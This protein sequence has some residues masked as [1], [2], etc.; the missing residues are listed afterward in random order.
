MKPLAAGE[1]PTLPRAAAAGN[2]CVH[3]RV[4]RCHI[5]IPVD[6]V[7]EA[8]PMPPEGATPLPRRSGALLGVVQASGVPVPVV[9]LERWLP[10]DAAAAPPG[11]PQLVLVLHDAGGQVGLQVDAV[12]GVKPAPP[13]TFRQVHHVADDHDE[14]FE[15]VT[16][17]ADGRPTLCRLEVGRL[18]RLSRVWCA[19]AE[20]EHLAPTG[21]RAA[22]AT[23]AEPN[24]AVPVRHAVFQ[25]GDERWAVPVSA[26]QRVVPVPAVELALANGR[27]N[28][29]IAEW[30]ARKLP[31]VDISAARAAS[32][33]ASAPWMA[34]L[35]QGP[36]ALGLTVAACLQFVD[37][38]PD[39][40]AAMPEDELLTGVAVLPG[41][42]KLRVLDPA[43]LFRLTPE[44]SISRD[45]P[46]VAL[47]APGAAGDAAEPVPYLV[48]EADQRYASPVQGIV[49][50]VELPDATRADLCAGAPAVL[51]WRGQTL[52]VM[53]LPTL[54]DAKRHDS[55]ADAQLAILVQPADAAAAPLGIAIKRLTDW[56]PAHSAWRSG[57]RMG[58]LG[59][60][61]LI[62]APGSQDMAS[63]VVVD[64][65]QM[66]YLLD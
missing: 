50:V 7:L 27:R 22:A 14:L 57:V 37:L 52:R 30:Q 62:D 43:K 29:A 45:A 24:G 48:F 38:A 36:L 47:H 16:P 20:A 15:S 17:A 23:Q 26:L 32:S 41:L 61:S 40:W 21:S 64:L 35:S 65:A 11:Q 3:V 13:G 5:A 66:A 1:P 9:A 51:A 19:E 59:A 63:L 8:M 31:L 4:G 34:L 33:R 60:F 12:L 46:P 25:I 10:I 44:T 2:A 42:G 28:W 56:L 53:A 39:A 18:M 6:Q 58:G 49:G 54:S 55:R